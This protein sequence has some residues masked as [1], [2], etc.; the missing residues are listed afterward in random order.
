MRTAMLWDELS[1]NCVHCRLCAHRCVISDGKRGLCQMR[2]NR[3]GTLYTLVSEQGIIQHVDPVEKKPLYHFYPGSTAYSI[4]T[5][6]CNFRCRW[7]QNWDI[8][9]VV[10]KKHLQVSESLS[11]T[12]AVV[13]ARRAGCRSIAYTYTEPTVFFEYAYETARLAH[14]TGL[15]NIFVT[16]GYMTADALSAIEPYLDAANVDLKAFRDETYRKYVGGR[17]QPVL[18]TLKR[19]A[20]LGIWL[21]VTTLVIPGINDDMTELRDAATFIADELGV[22]TPW[23]ISRFSPAHKMTHVAPTPLATLAKARKIGLQAGLRYVYVGNLPG[24]ENTYCHRCGRPLI[25]RDT[26]RVIQNDLQAR[27][28]CPDC[29]QPVAGLWT[30]AEEVSARVNHLR[31]AVPTAIGDLTAHL[32]DQR[33][34]ALFDVDLQSKQ[35][36]Q[37]SVFLVP[38]STSSA[39]PQRLHELDTNVVLTAGLGQHTEQW[40]AQLGIEVVSDV[41]PESPEQLVSHYLDG[42]VPVSSHE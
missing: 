32:R 8:S 41:P 17:L 13:A 31:I 24:E 14:E 18:D 10:S 28:S 23:H 29:G 38:P 19:M 34:W 4:A 22:D 5:S 1:D 27:G 26:Y 37:K 20:R 11:P 25:R 6:G 40:L 30:G 7:C 35:I 39:L 2:D 16:N 9:Q 12:R 36:T 42:R 3:G 15:A 21:E 33:E